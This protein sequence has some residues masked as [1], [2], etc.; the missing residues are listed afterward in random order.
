MRPFQ[1][2]GLIDA[3]VAFEFS[4]D[5]LLFFCDEHELSITDKNNITAITNN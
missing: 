1:I 4:A 5:M 2:P 3:A